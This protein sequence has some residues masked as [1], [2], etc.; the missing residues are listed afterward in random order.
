[1][2]KQPAVYILSSKPNGTLYVG[3][4]SDLVKR[5][6]E[7]KNDLG[8]GFT[9]IRSSPVGLLR[10]TC[11]YDFSDNKRKTIEKMEPGL[12]IETDPETQPGLERFMAGD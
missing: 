11:G 6:W 4:T 12:E 7:H 10:V 8:D 9:T 5:C 2:P 3:V 1:M